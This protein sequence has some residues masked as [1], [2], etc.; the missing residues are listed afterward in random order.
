M[1]FAHVLLTNDVSVVNTLEKNKPPN[2]NEHRRYQLHESKGTGVTHSLHQKGKL[3]FDAESLQPMSKIN[4]RHSRV[5]KKADHKQPIVSVFYID[6]WR[7]SVHVVVSE[8]CF[9]S[10]SVEVLSA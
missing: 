3:Y 1:Y 5:A 2:T 4:G 6:L 10:R 9:P 7:N 8:S